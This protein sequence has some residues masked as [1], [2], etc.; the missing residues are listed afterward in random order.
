MKQGRV[1]RRV[2]RIIGRRFGGEGYSDRWGRVEAWASADTCTDTMRPTPS[3]ATLVITTLTR[4]PGP[5]RVRTCRV[6]GRPR[7]SGR[8]W[9][10]V[11]KSQSRRA[12]VCAPRCAGCA[13]QV[14]LELIPILISTSA[15]PCKGPGLV[16]RV[17]CTMRRAQTTKIIRSGKSKVEE[18]T[19]VLLT[20]IGRSPCSSTCSWAS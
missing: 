2:G 9:W 18:K 3:P 17:I 15:S 6:S 13:R 5:P 7:P 12:P 14:G 8:R 1:G 20:P 16:Y 11:P 4:Q 19:F 10:R